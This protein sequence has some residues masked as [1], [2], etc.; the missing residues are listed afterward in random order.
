M[1]ISKSLIAAM[2]AVFLIA[3][4]ASTRT[5]KSPGEAIDD[6]VTTGR[7]KSALIEAPGTK[8]GKIDVETFRGTV[9]LNGFVDSASMRSEAAQV[10][11]RVEG[12]KTVRNNLRVNGEKSTVG[13][14]IDD[15]LLTGKVKAALIADPVTKARQINVETKDGVVQLSGFVD[16]AE[17][18][19]KATEVARD[20]TGV[21]MVSNKTQVKQKD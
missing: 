6:T 7:V 15:S 11:G 21:K 5:Q 19:S 13:E 1:Q 17:E 12:V 18:Q 9:Q 3:G 8:A 2:T 14:K 4:C 10:A 16:S 20:V